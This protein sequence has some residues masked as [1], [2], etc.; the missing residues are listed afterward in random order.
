MV[1]C[2]CVFPSPWEV[3]LW[4]RV[5]HSRNESGGFHLGHVAVTALATAAWQTVG[6]GQEGMF[7][8]VKVGA[9]SQ[10]SERSP[11]DE[12]HLQGWP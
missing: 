5:G 9:I 10:E 1:R 11:T 12:V 8:E 6:L 3:S 7:Q 4:D 2:S